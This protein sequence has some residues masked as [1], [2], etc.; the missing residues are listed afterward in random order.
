MNKYILALL[1]LAVIFLLGCQ[2][3]W[4]QEPEQADD[5]SAEDTTTS[6]SSDSENAGIDEGEGCVCTQDFNPVCANGQLYQNSCTAECVGI[7]D[8]DKGECHDPSGKQM[9]PCGPTSGGLSAQH[10]PVC[11]KV[12]V[13]E[14]G[15]TYWLTYPNAYTACQ[16]DRSNKLDVREFTRGE[17]GI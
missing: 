13:I 6:D 3:R 12:R 9:F 4:A 7:T 2:S 17:C 5:S 11:A 14:T 8:Y 10:N 16:V 15:E 1:V